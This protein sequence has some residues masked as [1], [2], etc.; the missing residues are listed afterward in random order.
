MQKSSTESPGIHAISSPIFPW[1]LLLSHLEFLAMQE[2]Q[3]EK[4]RAI[5]G[6]SLLSVTFYSHSVLLEGSMQEK[7]Q[8]KSPLG[9]A[10]EENTPEILTVMLVAAVW[11]SGFYM[12]YVWSVC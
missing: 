12:G 3:K 8:K 6:S 10:C 2:E 1:L 5:A 7:P 9:T 4:E 11:C